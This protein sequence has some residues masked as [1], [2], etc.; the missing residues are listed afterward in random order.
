MQH[1]RS[2]AIVLGLAVVTTGA[3][4]G[5]RWSGSGHTPGDSGEVD[6]R[7]WVEK[8][9]E[10]HTDYVH[11]AFFV[12][13]A[14][15]GLFERASSYDVHL[16]LADIVRKEDKLTV[17]FP[18]SGKTTTIAFT[19]K[20]CADQPPFDMCLDL[21]ENPWG[22]PKHYYGFSTPEDESSQLGELAEGARRR[23]PR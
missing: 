4:I 7:V 16:E 3:F 19:V 12:S 9:P 21:S 15:F 1:L 6:G 5:W 2:K 13:R 10:K 11:L 20:S 23:A 17:Y 22:G 8:R 18:Q 14:N